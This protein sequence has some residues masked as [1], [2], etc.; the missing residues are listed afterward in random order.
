MAST[1]TNVVSVN[2]N[3]VCNNNNNNNLKPIFGKIVISL[4]NCI[5]SN[6]KL[7]STPS[8][9]DGLDSQLEYDLRVLGTELIQTS[10]ILLKLPQVWNR[11]YI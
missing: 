3:N 11:I 2:N 10:G 5:L 7:S 1:L 8:M 4:E 9:N 6:D